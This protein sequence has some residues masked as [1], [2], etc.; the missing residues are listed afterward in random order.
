MLAEEATVLGDFGQGEHEAQVV[1][2]K[3]S[4]MNLIKKNTASGIKCDL[5]SAIMEMIDYCLREVY[6]CQNSRVDSSKNAKVGHFAIKLKHCKEC[7]Y[8]SMKFNAWLSKRRNSRGS[9]GEAK[10]KKK[11]SKYE[12]EACSKKEGRPVALCVTCFKDYH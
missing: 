12:C 5:E 4:L 9:N 11:K 3:F 7:R 6:R 2:L 8:C 1:E 10:P